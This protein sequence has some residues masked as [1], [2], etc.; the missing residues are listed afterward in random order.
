LK[1]FGTARKPVFEIAIPLWLSADLL[2]HS[3][4][5]VWSIDGLKSLHDDWKWRD[6]DHLLSLFWSETEGLK[7]EMNIEIWGSE[8]IKKGK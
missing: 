5:R 1:P 2:V 6:S 8:T 3:I 4:S 7:S